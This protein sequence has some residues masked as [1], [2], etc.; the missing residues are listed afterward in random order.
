L[1]LQLYHAFI[2]E[3]VRDVEAST[4]SSQPGETSRPETEENVMT[5]IADPANGENQMI[6]EPEL[7]V[8]ENQTVEDL[9]QDV[10]DGG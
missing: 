8:L 3:R 10:T 5:T 9:V 7:A 6:E 1:L 2:D 4:R